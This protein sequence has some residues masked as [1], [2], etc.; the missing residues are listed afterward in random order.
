M[1]NFATFRLP[2]DKAVATLLQCSNRLR[3]VVEA[4]MTPGQRVRVRP[5][6]R[7]A[8]RKDVPA[9]AQGTVLCCY[10]ILARCAAPERVRREAGIQRDHMGRG[11]RRIR[12]HRRASGACARILIPASAASTGAFESGFHFSGRCSRQSANSADGRR[13][14]PVALARRSRTPLIAQ[15]TAKMLLEVKAVLFNPDKPFIFTSGGRARS[16]RTCARSFPIP[17]CASASSISQ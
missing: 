2:R 11:R 5:A 6:S 10:K 1:Q 14:D 17:V 12:G 9:E 13:H 16:T 3:N 8:Q 15:E 7:I 4:L